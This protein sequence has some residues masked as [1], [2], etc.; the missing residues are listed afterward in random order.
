MTNPEL[1]KSLALSALTTVTRVVL[2]DIDDKITKS[3]L[4]PIILGMLDNCK[5]LT[6]WVKNTSYQWHKAQSFVLHGW[7]RNNTYA[8][9]LELYVTPATQS[10]KI[11][12]NKWNISVKASILSSRLFLVLPS[13]VELINEAGENA[14]IVK[15]KRLILNKKLSEADFIKKFKTLMILLKY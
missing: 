11:I 4:E 12:S 9:Q 1:A 14:E 6:A 5:D 10:L 8:V 2:G 7:V 15:A 13:I 3:Q